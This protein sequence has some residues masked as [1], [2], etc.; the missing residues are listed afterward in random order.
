MDST[1]GSL[2]IVDRKKNLLKLAQGEYVAY[3]AE[4]GKGREEGVGKK[5]RQDRGREDERGGTKAGG[6]EG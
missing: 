6:R 3:V 4:R 2:R 5:E 1:T